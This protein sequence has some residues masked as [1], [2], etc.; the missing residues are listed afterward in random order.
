MSTLEELIGRVGDKQLRTEL[1]A[2]AAEFR[3]TTEFGLV[4][5]THLPE[6][7]RLPHHPIRRGIKVARRDP[8]D[9]SM[10][11]V[12]TV[13]EG[14]ITVRRVRRPNGAAVS[15]LE[16]SEV[17]DE[18]CPVDSIVAVAEF[19]EAIYPG[20]RHLGAI[21]RGGDKPAHVVI[22]GE[23]H[24]ALEALQFTHAG[25]V[26]CIY[27]DP[28]Y[29]LGGDLT[30]NDR[31]VAKEDTFR[32]SKWLSFMDR[33]LRLAKELLTDTGVIIVAIDDTE[34][35]HLRLL[36]DQVFTESNFIATL[37]WQGGRK[38]DSRYVSVGHDYMLI[39][40]RSEAALS[41]KE[42]R[43]RESRP[44]YDEIVRAASRCWAESNG[45]T[46]RATELMKQW[47]KELPP[48]HPARTNNRFYEFDEGTGRVFRKDNI[49]W[50][51]G[52]G[53]RYDVLHPVT[54]KPV[55][56]PSSGWRYPTPERMQ[57]KI[58]AGRVLFGKDHTQYINRKLYL[59][60]A[61]TIVASSVFEQKRTG[62]ATALANILGEKRFS[63]PKDVGVL[64]RWID[65][66][67]CSNPGAVILDF[68]VG[69]GSTV[70]AVMELNAG[71][72]GHRQCIAVTNNEVDERRAKVLRK[73]G[74]APGQAEWERWGIFEHVT[75]PR[76][77][78]VVSGI[79]EDGS[80]YSSGL[81]ENVQ[82]FEL[83]Y[84]DAA[85][86]EI[87][88]AFAG[89]APLLWLRAGGR[90]PIIEDCL[91]VTGR[92]RPYAWTGQYGVLFNTDRWRSFIT[93]LPSTATTAYVV[94]DS[95]TEFAHIAGELPAHLD[96]VRLYERYLTTFTVNQR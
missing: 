10:F 11:E 85:R 35:A 67:T 2:A 41:Q 44:V 56:V 63:H 77:T 75:R 50:P 52:S 26:D 36:M 69:S 21:C 3:K 22:N 81:D 28:P 61:E 7:V 46:S 72:G 54:A 76:L 70:Q 33:R 73:K 51:G 13:E 86:V 6:T 39:Y 66:V 84:L 58:D 30:Y 16:A 78:T 14:T 40:A 64:A 79:R 43:W 31:R 49:S 15:P 95:N 88:L 48:D 25:N 17:Q 29:N 18:H 62:A 53:P 59:D 12:V 94:T 60:E 87:D 23:N 20:L 96:V 90:G 93:K 92:R 9:K 89:V 83:T 71:D 37:V 82:F 57:E 68:F 32:H 8:S 55:R 34:Q 27:I 47:I 1:Q 45:D 4:F 24:H 80:S 91:D 19:G 5:E 65:I 38:N 74:Y 42:V